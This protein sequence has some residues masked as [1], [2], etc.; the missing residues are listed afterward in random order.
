MRPDL[1]IERPYWLHQVER[2]RPK[3]RWSWRAFF[4]GLFWGFVTFLTLG[5]AWGHLAG[6][7]I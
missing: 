5:Y 3:R 4:W 6:R 1:I 2:H 7:G